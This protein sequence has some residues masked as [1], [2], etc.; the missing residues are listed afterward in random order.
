MLRLRL[1]LISNHQCPFYAY[2]LGFFNF[3]SVD[4]SVMPCK[5]HL[6]PI[7]IF[8]TFYQHSAIDSNLCPICLNFFNF[9]S[10]H[11]SVIPNKSIYTT[12]VRFVP[13]AHLSKSKEMLGLDLWIYLAYIRIRLVDLYHFTNYQ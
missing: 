6:L 2:M 3:L 10:V 13:F 7:C 1:L 12:F 4:L 5:T 8:C 9:F 11:L